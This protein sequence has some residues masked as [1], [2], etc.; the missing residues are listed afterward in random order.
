M[1]SLVKYKR[2]DLGKTSRY[3]SY[4]NEVLKNLYTSILVL[5]LTVFH[6]SCLYN[7]ITRDLNNNGNLLG[8]TE[9]TLSNTSIN[10]SL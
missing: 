4:S 2:K 1:R 9:S 5:L 8:L 6:H 10:H 7:S 3:S